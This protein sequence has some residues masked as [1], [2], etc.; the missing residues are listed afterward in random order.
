MFTALDNK[1]N[2]I[3]IEGHGIPLFAKH[4]DPLRGISTPVSKGIKAAGV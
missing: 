2:C 1:K 4:A 3:S